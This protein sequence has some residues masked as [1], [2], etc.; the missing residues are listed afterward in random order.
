M[1]VNSQIFM[2]MKKVINLGERKQQIICDIIKK[3]IIKTDKNYFFKTKKVK[4][5]VLKE[6]VKNLEYDNLSIF[7]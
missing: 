7:L 1:I 3:H 6:F 5:N 4:N 2:K